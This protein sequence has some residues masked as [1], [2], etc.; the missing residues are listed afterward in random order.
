[1]RQESC[2]RYRRGPVVR[3]T[4]AVL[5]A[6]TLALWGVSYWRVPV[7][8]TGNWAAGPALTVAVANGALVV[9]PWSVRGERTAPSVELDP[10]RPTVFY[11]FGPFWWFGHFRSWVVGSLWW[12]PMWALAAPLG[13]LTWRTWRR[14][15]PPGHCRACGYDVRAPSAAVC[16]ECGATLRSSGCPERSAL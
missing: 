2:C 7:L 5:L 16:P 6:A 10:L 12:A 1:M 9:M 11:D 3:W 13:V 8:D 14:Q 4:S 15:P